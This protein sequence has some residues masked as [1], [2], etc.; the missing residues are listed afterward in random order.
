MRF[1]SVILLIILF[2]IIS[3]NLVNAG[4]FSSGD[5][6]FSTNQ[7]EYYFKVG[8]NAVIPVEIKN[9]YGEQITG[10]LKYSYTQE[11]NQGGM[12]FT[13]SNSQSTD[14][15]VKD[16]TNTQN[17]DFGTS[18]NPSDIKVSLGFSYTKN[19]PRVVNLDGII[20][21][22][23]SDD[24]QKQNSPD[25]QSASSKKQSEA[26]QQQGQNK[27]EDQFSK[28]QKQIQNMM[29][30]QQNQQQAS[31][32]QKL[33]NSQMNQDSSALKNQIQQQ[34][35]EQ[36]G[37]KKEF[38]NNIANN[39]EFQKKHQELLDQGYK[40]TSGDINPSSNDS[41][42]FDLHYQNQNNKEAEL[43]GEMQNN[44]MTNM[45]S[46]SEK[47]KQ[48]IM[49]NLE[50]NKNFQNYEKQLNKDNFNETR[51][52]FSMEDNSTKVTMN[53]IDQENK[54]AT[55]SAKVINGTIQNLTM[56]KPDNEKQNNLLYIW[57]ILSLILLI[58]L[59]YV[60]YKKYKK[61]KSS[62]E[63]ID[64]KIIKKEFDYISEAEKMLE[65]SRHLFN[66]G[67]YKDAYE[68]AG[69]ALRLFLSYKHGFNIELTNDKIIK[70]LKEKINVNEIK[71]C[72]DLCSLVEFA[73]YK[74]NIEDF[75]KIIKIAKK[76]IE[77]DDLQKIKIKIKN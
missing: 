54:T 27:E 47:D 52:D 34:M 74:E 37:L 66:I 8:E 42:S 22:F 53:Y 33:Q 41:G 75:D 49:K 2:F 14:F 31:A 1:A 35:Q 29:Q 59:G 17:M 40:L 70:L 15:P 32:Q 16:G 12:H 39:P 62:I 58:I 38:Q 67:K 48:D 76:I 56:E 5:I 9:T 20:I 51:T 23:V 50:Q 36:E 73:K 68:K 18:N 65:N 30:N 28:M 4:L 57:V 19:E 71:E 46:L 77:K 64:N 61:K 55:I 24:N 60:V 3:I 6:T 13:N 44:T 26:S 25:K 72:F 45:Q 21:H 69:Q 10:V 63:N 7:K 43:K 11:I